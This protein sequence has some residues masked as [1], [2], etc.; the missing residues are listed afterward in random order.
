MYATQVEHH[1][2]VVK[3]YSECEGAYAYIPDDGYVYQKLLGH[4]STAGINN[5]HIHITRIF[6]ITTYAMHV[7]VYTHVH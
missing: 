2:T 1:A 7:H 5:V 4:I 3:H 6:R